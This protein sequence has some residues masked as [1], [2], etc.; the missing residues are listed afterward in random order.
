MKQG[1][2]YRASL[3]C[4]LLLH[5]YGVSPNAKGCL[6]KPTIFV[7]PRNKHPLSTATSD[8]LAMNLTFVLYLTNTLALDAIVLSA[9]RE[10]RQQVLLLRLG[11]GLGLG[12]GLPSIRS[13][14]VSS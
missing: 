4:Q 5:L 1:I 8:L 12:L 6:R 3:K 11:L 14:F 10:R 2:A 7:L 13:S 9:Q